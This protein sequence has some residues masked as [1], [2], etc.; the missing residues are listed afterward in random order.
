MKT[1]LLRGERRAVIRNALGTFKTLFL[2]NELLSVTLLGTII[3]ALMV[4]GWDI[5]WLT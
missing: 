5:S 3:L 1:H 2:H 4:I